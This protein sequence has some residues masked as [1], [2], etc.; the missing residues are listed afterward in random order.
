MLSKKL[1]QIAPSP[2]LSLVAKVNSMKAAGIDVVGF[3]G[4]E[5]DFDTSDEIKDAAKKSLDDGFTKYTATSGIPDLKKAVCEKFKTDNG[6]VYESSQIIIS[7]GAKHSLY[8]AI[9]AI[10]NDGDEVIL[11]APYWVSYF[12]QIRLAG[13]TPIIIDTDEKSNFKITA[14]MLKSKITDKTKLL[15]LNSPSNPTGMV[16][17]KEELSAI[18]EV[19]VARNIYVISDEIYEKIVYDGTQHVSIASLNPQIKDLTVV[20]NGVS[21]SYSMTGWRI[22]YAAGPKE[23]VSL[24]SNLQDHVTSNPV[25][26]V[27]KAT[28]KALHT[29]QQ[30]I[31]MMVTEFKKRRDYI[32]DRL[33]MLPGITCTKPQGSFYVFPN[34]SKLYGKSY[35]NKKIVDSTSFCDILL[36]EAMAAAVPGSGFGADNYMRLSYA[37]SMENIVKG[38]DRIEKFVKML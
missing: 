14:E 13:A 27:Q 10:C 11:P 24:M 2:T 30:I 21:K 23:I 22:G 5:P 20:I 3:G 6:L 38:L 34:I 17:T 36:D 32:V 15:I 8:N 33:N 7:C 28:I 4:G 1:A 18:A 29:N 35:N 16:Y 31:S 9:S 26:F 25:S 37:T 19:A 12:E